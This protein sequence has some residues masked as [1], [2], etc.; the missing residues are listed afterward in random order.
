MGDIRKEAIMYYDLIYTRCRRGVDILRSGQPMLSDGFKVYSC[1]S[2][3]Y[4]GNTADL[5]LIM[6]SAQKKQSFNEPDF[7]D[8][9]Y[10]YCVPDT[11][12]NFITGFHPVPYDLSVTGDF[13][14]R[15]G[16]YLNHIIAGDFK[17]IYLFETFHSKDVWT[18][19]EN[20]EAYY[21]ENET[22]DT[23]G[24]N[25]SVSQPQYSFKDI[26]DFIG[27]G[28]KEA[29]KKVIGF[30]IEQLSKSPEERK[31]LVIKDSTS[32][33]VE[34]WIAAIELAFSPR[35]AAKISF[36]TRMDK[37]A[38][39]N[40][41]YV[42][43][44][45]TFSQKQQSDAS[46]SPRFRALVIGVIDKDKAN[47]VRPVNDAPYVILDGGK[48]QIE[49]SLQLSEPYYDLIT[50]YDEMHEKFVRDFLQSFE[51]YNPGLELFGLATAYESL[52]GT[53]FGT[54]DEYA[55]ALNTLNRYKFA[56][57]DSVCEIYKKVQER[58]D[59]FVKNDLKKSLPIINWVGKTAEVVGDTEAKEKLS[60]IISG[61]AKDALFYNYKKGGVKDFWNGLK[62]GSFIKDIEVLL[63]DEHCID[64]GITAIR[65]YDSADAVAFL[66]LY[67]EACGDKIKHGEDT[68]KVVVSSCA[69]ACSK[70]Y[71]SNPY[72]EIISALSGVLEGK[73]LSFL[74]KS[75]KTYEPEALDSVVGSIVK[76]K[77]SGKGKI[78]DAFSICGSLADCDM[79]NHQ[80]TILRR[81]IDNTKDFMDLESLSEK[82]ANRDFIDS[83][84]RR[85]VYELL[86]E[87]VKYGD[88]DS[89]IL[90]ASIQ[91]NKPSDAECQ[92]S[93]HIVAIDALKRR[94]KGESIRECLSPFVEQGFPSEMP[95]QYISDL[96]LSLLRK[97]T[98]RS[99]Q[100]YVVKLL[101]NAPDTYMH[102]YLSELVSVAARKTETWNWTV[103]AIASYPDARIKSKLMRAL[104]GSLTSSSLKKKN[105]D[106]LGKLISDKAVRKTYEG[107]ASDAADMVKEREG[108]VVSKLFGGFRK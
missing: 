40:L 64:E 42:N 76:G 66:N 63:S 99:D 6:N 41:Y 29:L 73:A 54:V 32:E 56:K 72:T 8:D 79:S 61:S 24:R 70:T 27:D 31:Y 10:L 78:E 39:S 1:S 59:H 49:V 37:F 36:A 55:T 28:R 11:G 30:I 105:I 57:S 83:V 18:A 3:L 46:N 51:I 58:L 53:S 93:A 94:E 67:C 12:L 43:A 5:Q 84:T 14:K 52:C 69:A 23:A 33:N 48:K 50:S 68:A 47:T 103:T 100:E 77:E 106:S 20:N 45:G 101:A 19:Q 26:G 86:D 96:S 16:M 90:S 85:R 38:T 13:A 92:N 34:K 7:M 60:G 102:V 89:A 9:A 4:E 62:G 71:S 17:D 25:L 65:K 44:D 88:M 35:M 91:K 108:S 82:T 87:K 74:M 22:E 2:S 107:I 104:G 81:Y 15:P 98:T 97:E 21:Y 75:V 95:R 80:L